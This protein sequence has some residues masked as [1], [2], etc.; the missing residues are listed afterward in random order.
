MRVDRARAQHQLLGDVEVGAAGGHQP[1]DLGLA[2]RQSGCAGSEIASEVDELLVGDLDRAIGRE[3]TAGLVC[4]DPGR[5]PE[6]SASHI[7]QAEPGVDRV[8]GNLVVLGVPAGGGAV[9][10]GG[11]RPPGQLGTLPGDHLEQVGRRRQQPVPPL[12]VQR[13]GT[14]VHRLDPLTHAAGGPARVRSRSS[15]H[16][17]GCLRAAKS[18]AASLSRAVAS[19]RSPAMR[20][21]SPMVSRHQAAPCSSPQARLRARPS[22]QSRR[23]P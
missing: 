2:E 11:I 17:A 20:A 13:P 15:R 6:L 5:F 14:R 22:R 8:P 23:Q 9:Q 16:R 4:F 12:V 21:A 3:S 7:S 1:K 18:A 10:L 19:D